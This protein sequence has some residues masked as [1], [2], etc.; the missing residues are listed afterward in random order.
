MKYTFATLLSTPSYIE[1]VVVLY[2]SL[3]KYG[4]TRYPFLCV[5]SKSIGDAEIGRLTKEG[6]VCHQL[7]KTAIEGMDLSMQ[8][9][10]QNRWNNTFDKLLIWEQTGYDKM[11]FLDSDM[12][13]LENID[14][15]FDRPPFTAVAFGQLLF[16]W[17]HLN[18]GMMVVEPDKDVCQQLLTQI[19]ETVI[20]VLEKRGSVGDE[21]VINH[22]MPEWKQRQELHLHEGYNMF[23]RKMTEYHKRFGFSYS[24]NIKIVHFIGPWYDKPWNHSL[25]KVFY[26]LVGYFL[27]N[28]YG[29]KAYIAYQ[30][31]LWRYR[32]GNSLRNVLK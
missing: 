27:H 18:S 1:G 3:K 25:W 29:L 17:N 23:F 28:R 19:P 16:N 20:Q 30:R 14:D 21:D 13:V 9:A 32:I 2:R 12:I 15:L 11:V 31:M 5:C 8:A 4:K 26:H 7:W 10:G 24:K 6:I 22:Y